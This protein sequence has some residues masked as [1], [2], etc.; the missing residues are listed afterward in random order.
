MYFGGIFGFNH[1]VP[2]YLK[3]SRSD[4]KIFLTDL[5][6]SNR[7]IHPESDGDILELPI[8][9]TPKVRLNYSDKNIYFRFATTDFG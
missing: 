5:R 8:F 6:I 2:E 1:F 3:E 4:L 9:L 7:N